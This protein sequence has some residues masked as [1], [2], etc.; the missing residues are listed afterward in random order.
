MEARRAEGFTW[1]RRNLREIIKIKLLGSLLNKA[2]W[3]NT[4]SP[5]PIIWQRRFSRFLLYLV[6]MMA[7]V[8]SILDVSTR[9][10]ALRA[11]RS[12]S[13]S[14]GSPSVFTLFLLSTVCFSCIELL[15]RTAFLLL[16]LSFYKVDCGSSYLERLDFSGTVWLPSVISFPWVWYYCRSCRFNSSLN[17]LN[18]ISYAFSHSCTYLFLILHLE[19]TTLLLHRFHLLQFVALN[20][21]EFWWLI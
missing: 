4:N 6:P 15:H 19:K 12:P 7:D 18:I 14:S 1:L 8:R 2:K 11:L 17:F 13:C 3:H 9:L 5:L 20:Y 10:L 21:H 16:V